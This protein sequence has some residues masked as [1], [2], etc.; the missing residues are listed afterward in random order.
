MITVM[1]L[2]GIYSWFCTVLLMGVSFLSED[3]PKR[4]A[5]WFLVPVGI[6]VT[7]ALTRFFQ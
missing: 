1:L 2:F 6:F 4:K 5:F 3:A 7:F